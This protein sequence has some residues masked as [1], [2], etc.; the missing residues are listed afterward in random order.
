MENRGYGGSLERGQN[1]KAGNLNCESENS[2][3]LF[4]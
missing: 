3:S 4:R 1:K 2:G